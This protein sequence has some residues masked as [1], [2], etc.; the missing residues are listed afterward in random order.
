VLISR[1]PCQGVP[2][3]QDFG[4]GFL[5]FKL[6]Y[7]GTST[8]AI[9]DSVSSDVIPAGGPCWRINCYPRGKKTEDHGA[10]VSMFL[11]FLTESKHVKTFFH[12]FYL[13][14]D[15]EPSYFHEKR[16]MP[17]YSSRGSKNWGWSQLLPRNFLENESTSFIHMFD[18]HF[19]NVEN[20]S[21]SQFCMS[22]PTLNIHGVSTCFK[23]TLITPENSIT[24]KYC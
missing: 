24:I 7:L 6:D 21:M 14:R 23:Y 11:H 17:V 10:Y 19:S 16:S 13:G 3:H 15:G 12:V 2:G 18:V 22:A 9:G 5:K 4:S 20:E 8:F 1:I